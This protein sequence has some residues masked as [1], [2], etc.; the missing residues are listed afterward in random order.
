MFVQHFILVNEPGQAFQPRV[1]IRRL[2]AIHARVMMRMSFTLV[3]LDE[4]FSEIGEGVFDASV[5]SQRQQGERLALRRYVAEADLPPVRVP[6]DEFERRTDFVD[7]APKFGN[8]GDATGKQS[9]SEVSVVPGRGE[10]E[11]GR[12]KNDCI[13]TVQ[14][15]KRECDHAM[16]KRNQCDTGK[17]KKK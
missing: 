12:S 2:E 13:E 1:K 10:R 6:R 9:A 17:K 16:E 4:S 11:V 5:I 8:V 3:D 7:V 14:N 15:A